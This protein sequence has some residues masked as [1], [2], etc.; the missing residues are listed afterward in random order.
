M[1]IEYRCTGTKLEYEN[2]ARF[3]GTERRPA[4]KPAPMRPTH[5]THPIQPMIMSKNCQLLDSFAFQ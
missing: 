3:V 2:R 4:Q 1:D 5:G